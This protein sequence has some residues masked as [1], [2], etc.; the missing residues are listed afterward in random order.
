MLDVFTI[1]L[2][3]PQKLMKFSGT[4]KKGIIGS[5]L[6]GAVSGFVIGPCT[7]PVLAVLLGYVAMQTNL[8]LGLSLLFVFALG[9]GTLLIILG[10]FAGLISF[11]PQS[12]RW[13]TK[14]KFVFGLIL[15]GAGEYFLFIAGTLSY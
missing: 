12:G 15:I 5:F 3:I 4:I 9:M 6:L 8:L 7:A 10:T 2:P 11:L 13:M 14:I 1:T